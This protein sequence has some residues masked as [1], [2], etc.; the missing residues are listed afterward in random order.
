[1]P[2]GTLATGHAPLDIDVFPMDRVIVIS[3]VQGD[4][5]MAYPVD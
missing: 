4:K 3:G 2:V 1:V 5:R